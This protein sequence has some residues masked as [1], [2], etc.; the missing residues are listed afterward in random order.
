MRLWETNF[1]IVIA[2]KI[3]KTRIRVF[4][5]VPLMKK[6]KIVNKIM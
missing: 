4:V 6:V 5:N 2:P 1:K 3:G